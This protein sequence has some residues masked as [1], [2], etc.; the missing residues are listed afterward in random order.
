M[1]EHKL[2]INYLKLKNILNLDYTK[3]SWITLKNCDL[4]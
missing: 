4:C 3:R 2:I 1:P